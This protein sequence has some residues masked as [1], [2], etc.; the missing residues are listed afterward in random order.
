MSVFKSSISKGSY[1]N[2]SFPSCT[3][4]ALRLEGCMELHTHWTNKTQRN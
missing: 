3:Y 1:F 2:P 4:H